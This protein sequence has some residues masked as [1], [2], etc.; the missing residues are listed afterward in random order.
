MN[1]K[2]GDRNVQACGD[3]ATILLVDDEPAM[4]DFGKEILTHFGFQTLTAD[5]GLAALEIF[6]REKEH[7]D[8]VI[9]DLNM[10]KMDGHACFQAL[11]EAD[12]KAKVI[13]M[14]GYSDGGEIQEMMGLGAA[15]FLAKP[16]RFEGLLETV[17]GVL[18]KA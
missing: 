18:G 9:M 15:G 14:S 1:E 6:D 3:G 17:N 4:L 16:F 12:P 5:N 7:I 2:T 11:L 8:L 13:I 10:P